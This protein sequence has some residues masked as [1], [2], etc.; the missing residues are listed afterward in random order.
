MLLDPA[1]LESTSGIIQSE[2]IDAASAL[3]KAGESFASTL[4]ALA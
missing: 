3:A 2:Q 4:E 1:L